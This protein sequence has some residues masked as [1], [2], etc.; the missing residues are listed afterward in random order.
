[1]SVT[2]KG[3]EQIGASIKAM[4]KRKD[5]AYRCVYIM[6]HNTCNLRDVDERITFA[7]V[8]ITV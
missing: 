5:M 1:M 7:E 3:M 8:D 6:N 2:H 4:D